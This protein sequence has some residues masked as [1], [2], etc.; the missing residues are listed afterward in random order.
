MNNQHIKIIDRQVAIKHLLQFLVILI[1]SILMGALLNG[2]IFFALDIDASQV[3]LNSDGAATLRWSLLILHFFSFLLP[4]VLFLLITHRRGITHFLQPERL[5]PTS[6]YLLSIFLL[7]A[8]MP[9]I[10]YSYQVNQ[11]IPLPDWMQSMEGEAAD[12]LSRLIQMDNIGTLIINLLIIAVLPAL[13][14]ELLFRGIIQRYGYSLFKRPVSSVWV[15]AFL[16]SAIH[17]QFEGFIPRFLLG[18]FLGYLYFWTG[19]IVLPILAHLFNNGL[20]V[21]ASFIYPEEMLSG[22]EESNI[23]AVSLLAAIISLVILIPG[24]RYLRKISEAPFSTTSDDIN[25]LENRSS[26]E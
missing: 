4:S 2:L 12:T 23:P 17:F 1:G 25:P 8:M 14:E 6:W 5:T 18:L 13:G 21:I 19:R 20:M 10:Q 11:M 22:A 3:M 26:I 16:F 24:L 9:V 7:I 15:T